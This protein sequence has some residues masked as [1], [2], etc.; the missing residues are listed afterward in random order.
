VKCAST[1]VSFFADWHA[2]LL[3]RLAVTANHRLW[4][5]YGSV[6][7]IYWNVHY[8]LMT[9]ALLINIA[10]CFTFWLTRCLDSLFVCGMF[11]AVL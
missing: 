9:L 3:L 11:C 4:N 8:V 6:C 1:R 7:V 2:N 5:T 10:G